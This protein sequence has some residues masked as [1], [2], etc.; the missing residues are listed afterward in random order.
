[1]PFLRMKLS[2]G[3]I[4]ISE[5]ALGLEKTLLIR[6]GNIPIC[7]HSSENRK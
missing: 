4:G 7:T 2:H 5:M 1:V 6:F 3:P